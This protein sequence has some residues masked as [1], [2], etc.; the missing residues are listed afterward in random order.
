LAES[1][2]TLHQALKEQRAHLGGE[3]FA[4]V[5]IE[6]REFNLS[7]LA[8]PR[9]PEILPPAEVCFDTYPQE[10]LRIVDYRAKWEEG[11]FEYQHTPRRFDFPR[12][13]DVLLQRLKTLAKACWKLFGLR[14]YAR[15]DF[16]VGRAQTPWILEVNANPCLSPDAGFIAAATQAGLTLHQ[17]IER[18]M[19]D[20]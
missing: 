6:G 9:G 7:L 1:T 14:G 10:K 16:R 4:E 18:I 12:T 15:V 11:S 19:Q 13:D 3:G 5:Y 2:S 8:G 17:V 20:I